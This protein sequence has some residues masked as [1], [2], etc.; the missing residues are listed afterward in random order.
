MDL[1]GDWYF[2]S[3][4]SDGRGEF[5]QGRQGLLVFRSVK[6]ILAVCASQEQPC[7]GFVAA[8]FP[9]LISNDDDDRL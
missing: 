6:N 9:I 1:E 4:A 8:L 2:A 7:E 5:M 3:G